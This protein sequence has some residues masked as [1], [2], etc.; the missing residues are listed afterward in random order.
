MNVKI[1]TQITNNRFP[2][3]FIE[4]EHAIFLSNLYILSL[5]G[6]GKI[7]RQIERHKKLKIHIYLNTKL[8]FGGKGQ[9]LF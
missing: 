5:S 8:I 7:T 6:E 1:A 2:I 4:L 9:R 3:S